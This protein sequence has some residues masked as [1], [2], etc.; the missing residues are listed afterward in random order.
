MIEGRLE[1]LG[2]EVIE[3][4]VTIGPLEDERFGFQ[5]RLMQNKV[6]A[7][8]RAFEKG[9]VCPP[10]VVADV[11]GALVVVDGQHRLWA[12]R[13]SSF[14]L[15]AYIVKMSMA[16]ANKNFIA[17]NSEQTKVS[18]MWRLTVALDRRSRKIRE[19]ALKFKTSV[20]CIDNLGPGLYYDFGLM[21]QILDIWSADKRWT[22]S[23]QF[24]NRPGVLKM[25]GTL[26]RG[27]QNCGRIIRQLQALDYRANSSFGEKVGS[28]GSNQKLMIQ[29]VMRKL[30]S[31]I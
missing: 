2:D 8:V 10:I 7:M 14:H 30:I 17:I 16:E 23:S 15:P 21:E 13:L 20:T 19:L 11:N 6:N 3:K 26:C 12:R 18:R 28:S 22:D 24:Y 29:Y 31:A 5:R 27:K 9:V 1:I 25:I 4:I